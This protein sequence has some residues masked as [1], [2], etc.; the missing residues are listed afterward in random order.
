M[1]KYNSDYNK[2][3]PS[4]DSLLKSDYD[5]LKQELSSTRFYSKALSGSTY[6]SVNN[7]DNLFEVIGE[8]KPR[9]W[10]ISTLSSDYSYTNQPSSYPTP[11]DDSSSYNFYTKNLK[12]YGLTLKNLF[13]P[14]RLMKDILE[15]YIQVDVATTSEV[16]LTVVSNN[17][18]IDD[19]KLKDGHIILVKDQLNFESLDISV[20]PEDYF[21]GPYTTLNNLGLTID[22]QY[23]NENNG[24]YIFKKDRL[25]KLNDL[26]D[27]E[28]CSRL[29]IYVKMGVDNGGIQFHLRRLLNGFYPTSHLNDPMEFVQKHN[30]L[31]RNRV[32]YNNLFETNYYDILKHDSQSYLYNG[33]TYSIPVLFL[34]LNKVILI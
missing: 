20:N 19:I 2:W 26:D 4:T 13:T 24:L 11:I 28:K 8:W 17:Y 30:W 27:Y 15:N 34:I 23:Y 12:E 31:L 1:W 7:L 29:S 33:I 6:V 18:V 10:F 3:Y 9:N 16:D 5:W 22:Y 32:D 21:D 14:E 25:V